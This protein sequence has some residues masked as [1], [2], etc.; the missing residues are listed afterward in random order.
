[1]IVPIK[2][3][4]CSKA[5]TKRLQEASTSFQGW[6]RGLPGDEWLRVE[7]GDKPTPQSCNLPLK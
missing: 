7:Q 6:V 1:M 5:R 4:F 2:L 3:T